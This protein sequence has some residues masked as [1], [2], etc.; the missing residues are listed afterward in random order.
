MIQPRAETESPFGE[1][2]LPEHHGEIGADALY[3]SVHVLVLSTKRGFNG[4]F[5]VTSACAKN[6][7]FTLLTRP[8][9]D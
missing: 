3:M 9:S 6:A 8:V 5:E 7:L 1:D 4:I 2:E